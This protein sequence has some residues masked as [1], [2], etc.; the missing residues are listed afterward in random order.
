[1]RRMLWRA[2]GAISLGLG[3][4]G[5]PLPLLPTTPFLLLAA[6]CFGRSSPRLHAWL[7]EHPRLGPPIRD[8]QDHGAISRKAKFMAG[9]SFVAIFGLSIFL[10][11]PQIALI[12]QGVAIAGSSAFI[13]SR[14]A[15]PRKTTRK[16]DPE[17]KSDDD[18]SRKFLNCS[19]RSASRP[20]TN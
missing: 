10:G 7:V 20:L 4:I 11:A 9:G 13:F 6:F 1:M 18:Q 16:A 17:R 2:A 15:P 19:G 5:V 3:L 12:A 8:W 14:P